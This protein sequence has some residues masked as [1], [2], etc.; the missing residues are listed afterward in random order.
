[1]VSG[2][3]GISI[4]ALGTTFNYLVSLFYRRPVRQGLFGRPVF[5][6]PLEKHFAWLGTFGLMAGLLLGGVSMYLGLT[7][8]EISRLWL[9]LLASAMLILIGVQLVI[10]WILARALEELSEREYQVIDGAESKLNEE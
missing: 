8:W 10:S 3:A 7:G 9:Y 5:D 4:F 6:E 2:V 1:M